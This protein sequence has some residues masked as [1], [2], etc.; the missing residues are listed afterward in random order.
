M[1]SCIVALLLQGAASALC[2]QEILGT[3]FTE[4]RDSKIEFTPCGEVVCGHVS[5][6]LQPADESGAP[7]RDVNNPNAA[8]RGRPILGLT[9]FQGLRRE[10][11]GGPWV[12]S[13]Y[14]PEDGETY[15]TYLK[16]TSSGQLE[17]KGC[18][19]GGW[20]CDSQY[21]TRTDN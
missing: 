11:T 3:W 14:N 7:Y 21:W 16:I 15:Q 13:V 19:L 2:A 1:L 4:E 8:L 18:V 5:W 10:E 12:G 6:L 20:I 17:V 9:I